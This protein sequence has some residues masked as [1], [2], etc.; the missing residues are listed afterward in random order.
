MPGD[1]A[2][3]RLAQAAWCAISSPKALTGAISAVLART[4]LKY[5]D[6]GLLDDPKMTEL[7]PAG[8]EAM[9]GARAAGQIRLLGVAGEN[10]AIDAYITTGVFDIIST[11]FS[12]LSG[13]KERLRLKAALERDMVVLGYGFQPDTLGGDGEQPAKAGLWGKP[14]M[15]KTTGGYAFLD[16]TQSWTRE[17]LCLAYALTEPSMATVMISSDRIERLEAL[18]AV[19]DRDLPSG[20][21]AQIEMQFRFR[22]DPSGKK[23]A[24]LDPGEVRL[25]R[26]HGPAPMA[27]FAVTD[28]STDLPDQIRTFIADSIAENPVVLFMKGVP[29]QPGCGFLGRGGADPGPPGRRFR[30]RQRAAERRFAQRHQAVQATGRPSPALRQRRVPRRLGHR[31]PDVPV[32]RTEAV[33]DRTRAYWRPDTSPPPFHGEGVMRGQAP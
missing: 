1:S 9:K 7:P 11:R 17:D 27:E 24:R 5:I 30:R 6:A 21:G 20:V 12:L 10:D 14:R 4:G 15:N 23:H 31:A 32:G 26:A 19:P 13:W 22:L 28:V 8:L 2:C 18:A 16:E 3:R 25:P 33:H 29:D